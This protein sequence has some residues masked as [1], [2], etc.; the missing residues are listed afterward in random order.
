MI[1][2]EQEQ[3][4]EK[5][6]EQ[7]ARMFDN[8]APHYDFLNR[9]LSVRIDKIW[10]RKAV[11]ELRGRRLDE[12]LDV[13]SGT[14][15]LALAVQKRVRPKHITGIDISEKMLE[16]GRR[17]IA[18]KGL[19][20]QIDLMYGDS[21][22]IPFDDHTFDAVTVA[23]GVRNFENTDKGLREMYRVL[24]PEGKAVILEFSVP[25]NRFFRSLYLFYFLR[26]LPFAGR[27]IS[28]DKR[29]YGYLPDSVLSFPHGA[30]FG[31]KM[32]NCGFLN[33]RVRSLTFGIACIYTGTK[34][35]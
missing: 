15:D 23:F 19:E 18:Q 21:E 35:V 34:A 26:I 28:K 12:V 2:N 7:I 27:L 32:E 24:K 33:V 22:E 9:F 14:A 17:K 31:K 5:K 11:N 16:I 3:K 30:E 4:E 10:R 13:A 8:I 6:K 29:A 20:Q 25:R 1:L